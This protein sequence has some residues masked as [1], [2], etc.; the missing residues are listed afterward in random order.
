METWKF[1]FHII[2]SS[3]ICRFCIITTNL[4][5]LRS[6]PDWSLSHAHPF[7]VTTKFVWFLIPTINPMLYH[8]MNKAL[9]LW[10]LR[11]ILC[12]LDCMEF[13]ILPTLSNKHR[14]DIIFSRDPNLMSSNFKACN[15]QLN[16]SAWKPKISS[17]TF[18]LVPLQHPPHL[19]A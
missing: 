11:D 8:T 7:K 1:K 3:D 5:T 9:F 16:K 6:W 17:R 2:C 10:A 15:L 13:F 14:V 4:W 12:K 19:V 18:S